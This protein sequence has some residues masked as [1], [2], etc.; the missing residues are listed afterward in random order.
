MLQMS[1]AN[2]FA[3]F[4]AESARSCADAEAAYRNRPTI[5]AQKLMLRPI[6]CLSGISVCTVTRRHR[7]EIKR[8]ACL[9]T[10]K[11]A[12]AMPALSV[13]THATTR[14]TIR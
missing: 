4:D 10:A 11:A 9:I 5:V 13:A 6:V 2:L 7:D 1:P 14:R 3:S 12:P 8:K